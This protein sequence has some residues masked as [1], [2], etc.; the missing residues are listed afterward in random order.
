MG[1]AEANARRLM[2]ALVEDRCPVGD[3]ISNDQIQNIAVGI[4]I[5]E[6]EQEAAISFA[7]GRGWIANG[8][9]PDTVI[10]TQ[11]GWECGND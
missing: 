11:A 5:D 6:P 4:A 8:P 1:D 3:A 9:Q 10:L 2:T 7:G